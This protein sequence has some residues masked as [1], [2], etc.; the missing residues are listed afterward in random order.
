MASGEREQILADF[1]ACTQLDD[2]ETCIAILDQHDWNLMQAVQ[3]VMSQTDS[4][5]GSVPQPME[6]AMLDRP[7]GDEYFS[8]GILSDPVPWRSD[9]NVIDAATNFDPGSASGA[10][11]GT[12]GAGLGSHNK[13][14]LHFNVEYRNRNV[15]VFIDDSCTVAQIKE[16][17]SVD[18]GIPI[19][20]QELKGWANRKVTDNALLRDLHLPKENT[21]FLLTPDFHQIEPTATTSSSVIDNLSRNY[22]LKIT[23]KENSKY[24]QFNLNF[25]GTKT[26]EEVKRDT[27]N[28]SDIPVR[29][30][31]WTG[32]PEAAEDS[33]AIGCIGLSYP[34]HMLEL[35]RSNLS[36]TSRKTVQE[37]VHEIE[38]SEDEDEEYFQDSQVYDDS[39]LF[40]HDDHT[41]GRRKQ[42]PLMPESVKD[43]TEA[44]EHF[45]RE[46]RER[47]GETHPV[48]Y[49][50][51]LDN[52]IKDALV[53]SA[54]ERKLLAIYLHHD[55]SIL[56]NVFCSQIFCNVGIV[57]YLTTNF[58]TWAWDMTLETNSAR[59]ITMATRHFGSVA[60]NQ[61]RSYKPDNLPVLLII[62]R[63]RAT[64]E[65]VDVIRGDVT[66][67]ELM[68]KLLQDQEVFSQQQQRD[69]AEEA[70]REARENIR[71]EQDA[72]YQESLEADRKKREA[73]L[74]EERK[75][76]EIE[77]R[78]QM[79]KA[80]EERKKMEDEAMKQAIE[81]SLA[82]E[83]P[84]EPPQGCTEVTCTLR[85]RTPDR[86]MLL[87]KFYGSNKLQA[88]INYITSKGFHLTD[89]KLLQTYPRKDLS[90][91]DTNQT[92]EALKL[93]PQ[94]TLILE[95]RT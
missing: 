68:S 72:A 21:L 58:L 26:V 45:T 38:I 73:R 66:V 59:L 4:P 57:N 63:S 48:F 42:D 88:V 94:E 86:Q 84:E 34:S 1:Q 92:L 47:Y 65:V 41:G 60:A 28:V 3:S 39:E 44:L 33:K 22:N 25:P 11:P 62:S 71:T 95:E 91:E 70:E 69:I 51:S 85:I 24:H 80:E 56:A 31:I 9:A 49:V 35:T 87:R 15:D 29:H 74:A 93:C 50:G 13:R 75:Q 89:Y 18:L 82:K 12:S 37:A 20:K 55:S 43:E 54:R 53:V 76:Q 78:E 83:V 40:S 67:D 17:L 8:S 30:Q 52:A 6:T 77:R 2:I 61:I 90:N 27:Y 79:K 19:S 16:Q 46:F 36:S 14:M 32:W 5:T 7:L 23:C 64:N 10:M 81:A